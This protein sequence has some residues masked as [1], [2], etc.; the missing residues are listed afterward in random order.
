VQTHVR[1][2]R[3]NAC[4]LCHL[5]RSLAWTRD[6]LAEWYGHPRT[7][8]P[9][10]ADGRGA[11]VESLLAGDAG[12]RALAAWHLAWKPARTVAGGDWQAPLLIRTLEDPYAAVRLIAHRSLRSLPGFEGLAPA[13][14]E[15]PAEQAQAA[16]AARRHGRTT[17][18]PD[19]SAD[20]R[21]A[22]LLQPDGTPDTAAIEALRRQRNNRP[23]R[24]R[25]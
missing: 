16:E 14:L 12:E 2:G 7:P 10:T 24:L 17:P 1:T 4:N 20:Q 19:R 13:S 18:A 6:R 5:D 15:T 23:M 25:E 21:R 11:V 3:P 22:L 9:D 8:V